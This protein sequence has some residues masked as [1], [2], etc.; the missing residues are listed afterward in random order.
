ME[1]CGARTM[2]HV[3]TYIYKVEVIM[4]LQM[5]WVKLRTMSG[6]DSDQTVLKLFMTRKTLLM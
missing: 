1:D 6:C 5:P 4:A 3:T 2:D